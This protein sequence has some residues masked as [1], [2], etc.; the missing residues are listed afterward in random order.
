MCDILD[1]PGYLVTMD[2]EKAFDSLDHDF[3]LS[4]FKKIGLGENFIHWI[5]VLL[6]K[7][8]SCVINGRFTTRYFNLEKDARQG[9][10]ISAYLFILALEVCYELIRNNADIKRLTIFNNAF[11]Y[12]SFADDSTFSLMTYY[13]SRI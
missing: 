1:I 7:Q 12:T 10:P 6:N 13:Q 3:L 9:D 11:L 5:K 4:A 2:I 8:Q